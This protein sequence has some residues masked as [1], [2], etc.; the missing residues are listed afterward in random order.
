VFVFIH[1]KADG[2]LWIDDVTLTQVNE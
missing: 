2:E 1:A